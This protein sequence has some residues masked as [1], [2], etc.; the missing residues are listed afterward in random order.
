[1][2]K[3]LQLRQSLNHLGAFVVLPL[4]NDREDPFTAKQK[5]NVILSVFC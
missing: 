5:D 4:L 2:E 1:M 3:V